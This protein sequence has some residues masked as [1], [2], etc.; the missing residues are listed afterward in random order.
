[1][2]KTEKLLKELS[3]ARGTIAREDE[4]RRLL[5]RHLAPLGEIAY[6]RLGS[7]ICTLPGKAKRPR[8]MLAAHMDEVGFMVRSITR[9]GFLRL[10][11]LG[12]WMGAALPGQRMMIQTR[13]GDVPGVVGSRPPHGVPAD[14]RNM[15]PA[16]ED[17]YLDIGATC[18]ED[19]TAAGIRIGDPVV[20]VA[21]FSRMHDAGTFVGKAFDD[22]VGCA[23]LIE[24]LAAFAGKPHPNMLLGVATVQEEP[25]SGEHGAAASVHL[26]EPDMAIILECGLAD[27]TPEHGGNGVIRLGGGPGLAI[28]DDGM[29]L[30]SA[31]REWV[32]DR[33]GKAGIPLQPYVIKG[34]NTDGKAIQ[35][36]HGGVPTVAFTVPMRYSHCHSGIMKRTDY[37]KTLKLVALL[38]EGL[39]RATLAAFTDW[40]KR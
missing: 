21:G 15:A 26:V 11:L 1:M 38:I 19:V 23:L 9:D 6:D 16:F 24:T 32:A 35:Q 14:K 7:V 34:G 39:D 25:A 8:I 3:E 10:H 22:R 30:G 27:D 36:H 12:G 37:D 17:L 4:V 28:A 40:S 13:G 31:L 5:V 18:R 20:P 33:A 29:L 2:D